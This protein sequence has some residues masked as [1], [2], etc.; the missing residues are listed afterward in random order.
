MFNS[1]LQNSA[2]SPFQRSRLMA[3]LPSVVQAVESTSKPCKPLVSANRWIRGHEW[4]ASVY[5]PLRHGFH[6]HLLCHPGG[7]CYPDGARGFSL[8]R[9]AG[10]F[11]VARI[12][13]LS[14]NDGVCPMATTKDAVKL[15]SEIT[16]PQCGHSEIETMP[17]NACQWFY[18]CKSCGALLKPKSGDCCVFCSYGTVPCPPIQLGNFCCE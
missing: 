1:K 16:C 6:R 12:G 4:Q 3:G 18:D 8:D 2:S 11:S 9:L 17:T 7:N 5:W 14:R 13:N 10:L 15:R